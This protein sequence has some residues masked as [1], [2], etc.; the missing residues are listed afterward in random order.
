M[1]AACLLRITGVLLVGACLVSGT[2]GAKEFA[3]HK[4]IRALPAASSRPAAEGPARYADA[5]RG[6]DGADGSKERPWKTLAFA[7]TK[8]QPGETLYLRAGT[9]YESPRIKLKGTAANP[10]TIRSYPGELAVL[11]AGH[12]EFFENPAEAWEPMPGGG[13][14]E[15][16]SKRTFTAGG[17]GG[18]FGDSMIPLHRHL[19]FSDLRSENE[20]MRPGV[21]NRGDDPVG[22]YCGPGTKR[23]PATGRIHVRLSHTK[24]DGLD[25]DHYRGETDP[26]KIPLVI[27]GADFGLEI[28]GSEHLR[29]QDLVLRG[30]KDVAA[31]MENCKQIEFDGVTMY[32]NFLAVRTSRVQGL[33]IIGC[34]LRGHTA[35]WL[36]RFHHKNRAKSGYLIL[37]GAGDADWEIAWS[38]LT[39][40]HDC[41]TF[42]T[43]DGLKLHHSL[44]DNFN[45]DGIEPGPKKEKGRTYVYQNVI[46]RVLSPFTAHGDRTER[47]ATEPGSGVY[48]YRNIID[49][50]RGTYF[51]PPESPDSQSRKF[52]TLSKLALHDHG[53]P[54]QPNYYVYHNTFLMQESP[55]RNYYAMGWGAHTYDS[56]RRIFNNVFVQVEEPP[57]LNATAIGAEDDFAAD[58]NLYWAVKEGPGFTGDYFAPLRKPPLAELSKKHYAPG[59]SAHD[60]FADPKFTA[61]GMSV[62]GPADFRLLPDSPAIDAGVAIPGEWPDPLR[63]SDK[64]TPDLGA[65]PAGAPLLEVGP[66]ARP[67]Q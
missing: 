36:S 13:P 12:R 67:K 15:Y 64:G 43:L 14:D 50:R 30:A 1:C 31:R 44:I 38:E 46:S 34:A 2:A 49:L 53:G 10:I 6:N 42:R 8:L 47:F 27:V 16:R 20:L 23:D 17:T 55:F 57:M 40:H 21:N 48:V 58:G 41:M 45:D 5:L 33:R 62:E 51:G 11:D 22:M 35:P 18:N 66:A 61:L 37:T 39:D 52:N 63:A 28:V 59:W 54:T 65:L 60:R 29:F 7:A 56:V 19:T 3:S 24:L 25:E 9:F 26:R 32:A 4:P